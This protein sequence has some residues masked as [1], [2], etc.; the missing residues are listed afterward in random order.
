MLRYSETPKNRKPLP[1]PDV[2]NLRNIIK[3]AVQLTC[4]KLVASFQ[5]IGARNSNFAAFIDIFT[6]NTYVIVVILDLSVPSAPTLI[7]ICD[8]RKHF[9]K[10]EKVDDP[11]H[12]LLIH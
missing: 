10:L 9:G 7:N 5:N 11:K 3:Q 12:S 4:S 8:A 2:D 1:P 6:L